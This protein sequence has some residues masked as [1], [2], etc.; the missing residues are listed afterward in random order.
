MDIVLSRILKFLNGAL[1]DDVMYR[2]GM[3]IVKRYTKIRRAYNL[4]TDNGIY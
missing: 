3:F 1:V 2:I 4:E